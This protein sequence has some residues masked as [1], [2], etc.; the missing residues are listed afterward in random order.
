[1]KVVQILPELNGG[2]VERGTLEVGRYLVEKGHQSIVISNGG[3][4]VEELE[5]GGSRHIT[6]PVHRKRLGSLR[7]V[8]VL[9]Q[10]LVEEK[11]DILHLRSRLPAWLAW[12][13][14]RKMDPASRPRLVTTVHGFYS[15]NRYSAIM[16]FGERVI[17]VSESVREYVRKNYPKVD[18]ESLTVIHRGVDPEQYPYG[19]QPSEA[20]KEEFYQKFPESEGKF[21]V[22]MPGRLTRWKGQLDFLE[23]LSQLKSKGIP[24]HG[25][26]VGDPHPKKREFLEEIKGAIKE[27]GLGERVSLVGHRADLREVMALADIVVDPK[28]WTGG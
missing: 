7:Q 22:L 14:W 8:R 4:M 6:L 10:L 20:W 17:C 21:L 26:I 15:V 23:V 3:R 11:P 24:A 25:L 5:Q 1:M 9:R 13:A 18:P 19:Y 28:N 2:G 12:L 27:R 16:T